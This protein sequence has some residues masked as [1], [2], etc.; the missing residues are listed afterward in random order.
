MAVKCLSQKLLL[1]SKEKPCLLKAIWQGKVNKINSSQIQ[2]DWNLFNIIFESPNHWN[3][4][5]N[6]NYYIPRIHEQKSNA[7]YNFIQ[8]HYK[9]NEKVSLLWT[10]K[11][12]LLVFWKKPKRD[13]PSYI[14]RRPEWK[15]ARNILVAFNPNYLNFY[16]LLKIRMN[17]FF[18]GSWLSFKIK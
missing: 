16:D 1:D 9:K 17:Y 13:E 2:T 6:P 11:M 12:N 8:F 3:K 4:K 14:N 7:I 18:I 10:V 15:Q 5:M